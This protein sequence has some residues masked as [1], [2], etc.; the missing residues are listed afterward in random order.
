M[1]RDWRCQKYGPLGWMETLVKLIA[2]GVGF[3]SLS[4]YNNKKRT[5]VKARIAQIV[6]LAIIGVMYVAMFVQRIFDK[7]LFAIGFM[8]L[9]IFSHWIVVIVLILSKEPGHFIFTYVFLMIM[10]EYIKI[11]FLALA[12]NPEVKFFNKPILFVISIVLILLYLITLIL[13]VVI[14]LVYYSSAV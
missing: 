6:L 10:G 13:Q 3:A 9:Q 2:I 8:V 12:E 11:M 4:I 7:E 14:W 1:D 5:F